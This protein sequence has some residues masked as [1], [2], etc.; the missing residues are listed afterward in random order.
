[1]NIP[2]ELDL[3]A[4]LSAS[5]APERIQPLVD[6]AIAD[7]IKYAIDSATG[8]RSPFRERLQEQ[9]VEAL[10]H[11]LAIDDVAKFQHVLN[12]AISTAVHGQNSEALRVAMRETVKL[13]LPH[14]ESRIKLS[15]LM[16]KARDGFCKREY[17]S[18]YAECEISSHGTVYLYLAEDDERGMNKY[19]ADVKMSITKEGDVY[20][21]EMRGN[22]V[23]YRK[24]P[25]AISEFDGL[26]L[27]LYVGR[28]TLEIDMDPDDVRAA[29][30]SQCD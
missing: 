6:K 27:S 3:H 29:A 11:G 13:A 17:E 21:L 7:A 18:F 23:T 10:P 14:V 9:L 4:I 25:T 2:I 24:L 1:M 26:L 28:C 22:P 16:K 15:D 20:S 12:S 5:L 30:E 8:Y 19:K